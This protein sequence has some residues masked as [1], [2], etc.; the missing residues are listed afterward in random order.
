MVAV[1]LNR[2]ELFKLFSKHQLTI[3]EAFLSS[4]A[5]HIEQTSALELRR[6]IGMEL[7]ADI[8]TKAISLKT[9]WCR[10]Q[11]E[12]QREQFH[13][14][15]A[16][17]SYK[18][19]LSRD[20]LVG[21]TLYPKLVEATQELAQLKAENKAMLEQMIRLKSQLAGKRTKKEKNFFLKV[22]NKSDHYFK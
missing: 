17:A 6:P 15:S 20:A 14:Y 16:S 10:Q 8:R 2:L 22:N 9:G 18:L 11:T 19:I 3:T 4:V 13:A 5:D 21:D 12:A 1:Q 7:R